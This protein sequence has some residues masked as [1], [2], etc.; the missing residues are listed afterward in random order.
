[1]EYST[2]EK[3]GAGDFKA[4]TAWNGAAMRMRLAHPEIRYGYPKEG[5][6]FWSD[7]LVVLKDAKNVENAKQFQ[8]YIMDPEVAAKLSTFH[9]Y[10]NGVAGSDKYLPD[11]MKGAPE[12]VIPDDL[13]SHGELAIKCSP[14]TQAIST[15][16]WTELTK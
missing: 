9:R 14:E 3:M 1:M 2:V 10:A 8:N 6:S 4:T 11:E 12:L 5:F 7:N 13:K 15:K 16:I